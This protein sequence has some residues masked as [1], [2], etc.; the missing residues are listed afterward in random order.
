MFSATFCPEIRVIASEFMNDYYYVTS[1]NENSAN[2]NI[3]QSFFW[4]N[5]DNDKVIK[6]H[7]VLQK[8]NGSVISNSN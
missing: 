4:V 7:E 1:N 2:A 6:L 3:E 5:S 8:I